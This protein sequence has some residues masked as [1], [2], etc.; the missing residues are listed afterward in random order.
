[1]VMILKYLAELANTL[2]IYTELVG[3]K[4][5]EKLAIQTLDKD[6]TSIIPVGVI[7]NVGKE[8]TFSLKSENLG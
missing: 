6:D 7:A 3:D 4:Q 2:A 5:G 8:I 1:M